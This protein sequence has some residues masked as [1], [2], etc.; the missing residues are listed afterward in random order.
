MRL[1]PTMVTRMPKRSGARLKKAKRTCKYRDAATIA[2]KGRKE[3]YEL[4]QLWAVNAVMKNW[5]N[6]L[7][8]SEC[9]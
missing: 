4:S 7:A 2:E 6:I 3:P 1:I 8:S 5:R 9:L